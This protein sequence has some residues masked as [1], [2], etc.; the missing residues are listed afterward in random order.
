MKQLLL[1][2]VLAMSMPLLAQQSILSP[3][4]FPVDVELEAQGL[5]LISTSTGN[6]G[7][8]ATVTLTNQE[9]HEIGCVA[10]FVNGPEKPAPLR[11]R[12]AAGEKTVLTQAFQRDIIRVRASI[13]C[14]AN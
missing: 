13:E 10:T 7:N 12:L 4:S 14:N 5:D 3:L 6:V 2:G 11:V 1:V 9:S 8:I